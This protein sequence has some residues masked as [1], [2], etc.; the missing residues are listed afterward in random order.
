MRKVFFGFGAILVL[1]LP[2]AASA[3]VYDVVPGAL[4]KKSKKARKKC[5]KKA[6]VLP[7]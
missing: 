7:V 3:D 1:A 2:A 6:L 4:K 5:K